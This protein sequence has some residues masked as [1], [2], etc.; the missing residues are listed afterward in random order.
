MKLCDVY[1]SEGSLHIRHYLWFD[2]QKWY[3]GTD[4][5]LDEQI[6]FNLAEQIRSLVYSNFALNS[7]NVMFLWNLYKA[8]VLT[9][10]K[11]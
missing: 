11:S 8:Q 1:Y 7:D 9:N 6:D 10:D 2:T 4:L 3:I 5:K